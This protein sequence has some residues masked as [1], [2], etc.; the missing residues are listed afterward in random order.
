MSVRVLVLAPHPFF[1]ERGTPIDVLLVLRV[2]AARPDV[3][4]DVLTYHEG[5]DVDLPGLTVYRI[6]RP[7]FVGGVRPGF[8]FKKLVCDVY[9][10][11]TFI[12]LLRRN[13][14]D[15]VHAGE[16]AAFFALLAKRYSGIPYAYDLDSSIAQQMVESHPAL[17]GLGA[18]FDALETTLMREATITFPVCNLLAKRCADAG[19]AKVVTLHDISQLQDPRPPRD[20]ELRA[21]FGIADEELLVLYTGNLES[22]QGVDLLLDAFAIAS[23]SDR[24]LRLV[25]IGGNPGHV[26][27]C[28][29]R[30]EALGLV[31]RGFA[32]GPRPFDG[33]HRYLAD[34]DVLA[35]PRV[36]GVNTPMKIFPYLHSGKPLLAT[37][38]PTHTQILTEEIAKLASPTPAAFS[39]A[40]VELARDPVER[41]RLGEEGYAFVERNHTFAAH[42][43]RLDAAYDWLREQLRA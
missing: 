19:A 4:V 2:L 6:R 22:Y 8:S 24:R 43:E 40:L 16:E 42:R 35:C 39:E 18:V 13:R 9:M 15:L 11:F 31:G 5:R 7:P 36:R 26:R 29:E 28:R 3:E 30:I 34:A 12:R 20:G 27:N 17:R 41:A 23:V 25:I 14:Y 37:A 1:E 38:L 32:A 33:L 21:E 10:L